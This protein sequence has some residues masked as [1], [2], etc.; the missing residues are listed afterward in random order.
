MRLLKMLV[1]SLAL[2]SPL[3][4][5]APIDINTA[6]ADQLSASLKGVGPA[7]ARA[8]IAYRKQHGA[9]TSI[10][11]LTEVKGIGEATLSKN[12][13]LIQVGAGQPAAN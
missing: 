4:Y 6:S 10:D 5:S 3:A 8:I 11:Q 1:L 7:K 9:F 13:E 2:L 12:R